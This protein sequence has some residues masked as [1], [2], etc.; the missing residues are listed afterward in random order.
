MEGS[1]GTQAV[2]TA[3][4]LALARNLCLAGV[5]KESVELYQQL[6]LDGAIS[7]A[8]AGSSAASYS[9]LAY[10]A[11]AQQ[12]GQVQLAAKALQGALDAAAEPGVQLA[13]VT[14]LL[15][16]R[17]SLYALFGKGNVLACVC[18][19]KKQLK[20]GSLDACLVCVVVHVPSVCKQAATSIA[21]TN[22]HNSTGCGVQAT[23]TSQ[24]LGV[25]QHMIAP[26][27]V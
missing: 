12:E 27:A 21:N 19:A 11:A 24:W 15:Q 25:W 5:T 4:Q 6:E 9:W 10:G 23:L 16:V 2:L 18:V 3:L 20:M 17:P 8:T 1:S 14:A 22:T 13:A 7:T 26:D